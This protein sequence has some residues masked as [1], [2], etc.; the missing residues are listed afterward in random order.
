MRELWTEKYRPSNIANYVF[1]DDKQKAQVTSW[2]TEGALP[3]LLFSGAPGTGKTTLAK[4]L[5]KELDVDS[6]DILEINASNEN[7][8][9]T[10]RNKITNFS[11]TMPFGDLKYVLLDEAD[12]ITPN[13]QA[14]LRGVMETFHTSC[15]FILTCNY[16]QRIIP[17]LHSRCQGFHIEKLDIQ[18]F[19]ARLATICI[20]EGVGIDLETL[21]T[22][23][24]ASYPDLRK[25]INL[26]QQNVV[27]GVL[28][29]P[30]VGDG[31]ASDW[32]LDVVTM[33]KA[34]D[35]KKARELIVT[36][37]RPEEYEEVY[38]FMYR[39]VELWGETELQQDQAIV[40]IRDGI[41]KRVACA[42]PEINLSA[43]LIEL[44]LNAL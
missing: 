17:A 9:D 24:Q 26:V 20:E 18:E 14:A 34:S 35:Y 12:Y 39:N 4:V 3:H 10:I 11:S 27:E 19:T 21:D 32:M 40:I 25:S 1:R 8:V 13:G 7:N 42:D 38:K 30:Q 16:P 44:Q 31:N 33:F 29:A 36:Q 43:T 23:V 28:Q 2:V 5:L 41:V 37:A 15:R 6:L 22:Y